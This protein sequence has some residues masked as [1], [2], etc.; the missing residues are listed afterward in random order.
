MI[1]RTGA[2]SRCREYIVCGVHTVHFPYCSDYERMKSEPQLKLSPKLTPPPVKPMSQVPGSGEFTSLLQ[3]LEEALDET[4]VRNMKL[5]L[6]SL[7]VFEEEGEEEVSAVR[8]S[9][10]CQSATNASEFFT[11]MAPSWNAIDTDLLETVVK[12]SGSDAAMMTLQNFLDKRDLDTPLDTKL[13]RPLQPALEKLSSEDTTVDGG[14]ILTS[15]QQAAAVNAQLLVVTTNRDQLSI[16]EMHEIKATVAHILFLPKQSLVY[17]DSFTGSVTLMFWISKNIVKYIAALL[18]L[19]HQ[20]RFLRSRG[21]LEVTIGD[22][23]HLV[24]PP[25]QVGVVDGSVSVRV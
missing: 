4:A 21:V 10:E 9:L 23:Y 25:L 14:A 7:V 11:A 5:F 18:L 13:V 15:R 1:L 8:G 24:L 19:L 6:S 12:A 3:D 2:H 17:V 22:E 20:L 16:A